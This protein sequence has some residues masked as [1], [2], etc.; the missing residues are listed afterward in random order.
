[1]LKKCHFIGIG[2][3]GMS[4]LARLMLSET[5]QVTGSDIAST[6]I[7]ESL[8]Q[9]GAKIYIGHSAQNVLQD[10]TVIYSTDIKNDNPEYQ[11][12]LRLKC[13]MLHRSELLQKIMEK[14]HSLA[15]AGTHGKTTTSS[16]LAWVLKCC[17]QSPSYAIGGV[18]PQLSANSG[19]GTGKYF[20]A[21]ACES[22]GTFLNYSPFGAIVTNID[23]DHMDHYKTEEILVDTFRAFM[24]KVSSQ[25]HLFWCGDDK[26]LRKI[27]PRGVS[28]GFDGS[29]KLKIV[30]FRQEGWKMTFDVEFKGAMYKAVEVSLAGKHNALNAVAVF[31]LALSLGLDEGS[32]RTALRTFAGV[33]RR[34]EKKGDLNGILF[35]DDYGHHPT[36]L[37]ATL[38]SIRKAVGE[39][40]IVVVYQPHRYT[41]AKDCMGSYGGVFDQADILLVP[42]IYSAREEPIPGITHDKIIEEIQQTLK[43]RCRHVPRKE[44]ADKLC[45][46]L[47]PH[48]V[49]VTMGAGD[50]TK[51]SGE[52]LE[53]FAL[54]AP[55]K[56]KVGVVYGGM[57]VEHDISMISSANIISAMK[58]DYYDIEQFGITRNG[59]WFHGPDARKQMESC[60]DSNP[61]SGISLEA[62][63]RLFQCDII[64]PVLHG[65]W[66]E[67]GTIQGLF[68]VFSKA[69]VGCDHRASAI[70][71]D[72]VMT[73]RLAMNAGIPTA[74]YVT[75]DRY[76]WETMHEEIEA[77]INKELTYPLFVKPVHLGSSI[78]VYKVSTNDELPGAIKAALRLDTRLV[79]EN[80]FENIRE[81]EFAVLGNDEVTVF[82]PGEIYA[83]G[84]LHDYDSK[85]GLNPNKA[86]NDYDTKAKLT[87]AQMDE[88]M[89]L[90][91]ASYKTVGCTGL[92]RIDTFLDTNGKFWLNEINPI[93]GFTRLSLYPLICNANGLATS[94]L[95]DKLIILGLQRRRMLDRLEVEA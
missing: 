34:C 47:K 29:N 71:M 50:V 51:I 4:G 11:A 88:G 15:V 82:P 87:S 27:N 6:H 24:D 59:K 32:I 25:S 63:S 26:H 8:I 43:E 33:Q 44:M 65:T 72:K 12:A 69:Y 64:F 85:Y 74:K 62:I 41:R 22:D 66:G 81:I 68:D 38:N 16:L 49:V 36:E 9:A 35:L 58:Q 95:I 83:H 60:Q 21:E 86:A 53:R 31:G 70:A 2:G 55:P 48:D 18:V 78:G 91:R 76:E 93:P 7:T 10:A 17:G 90:A 94:D 20:V 13:K 30:N 52:V 57:S 56:L 45:S 75:F 19:K 61:T 54:K 77:K 84:R 73:K 89:A 3:I 46:I 92:A 23:N 37:R 14:Y 79:I 28:Y 1:M 67:D 5:T 39:R 42:E 80:G 40:R